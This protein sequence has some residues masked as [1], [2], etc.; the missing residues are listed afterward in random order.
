MPPR[1]PF[2]KKLPPLRLKN[3]LA[4]LF[5]LFGILPLLFANLVA[6]NS[7]RQSILDAHKAEMQERSGILATKLTRTGYLRSRDKKDSNLNTEIEA[8]AQ[9][10]RGRVIVVD[11][12]YRIIADSFHL[13]E[14]RYHVAPEVVRG[15][16][17]ENG[18]SYNA[19]KYYMIQ[20]TPIYNNLDAKADDRQVEGVLLFM[21]STEPQ[22]SELQSAKETLRIF[23]VVVAVLLALL[24]ALLTSMIMRPFAELRTALRKVS[25]GDLNQTVEQHSYLVTSQIS[26]DVNTTLRKLRTLNESREEFVS[27]VSHELKTPITS[28]RVLADSLIGMGDAP[29]ELYKEFM[30]D[31]SKEIDR[32]AKIIDDLLSLVRMDRAATVLSRKETN[33]HEML[34][35]I[36]KRLRPL[37]KVNQ[38]ELT[39]HTVREVSADVDEVKFSL[40]IMN[41]VENGIKYNGKQKDGYVQVSLDADH[42]F[43]YIRVEDNGIGIPEDQQEL[44][45]ERFHRVDKARSRETGGTGLGLAI[46]KEIILL[47]QGM[48]RLSSEEGKGTTFQVRIPLKYIES[49]TPAQAASQKEK[50][51]KEEN[52]K[53]EKNRKEKKGGE[54][55]AK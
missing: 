52:R 47:H 29:L 30:S 54:K 8:I 2:M 49:S 21:S 19:D 45:F 23:M 25:A 44:V 15:F 7:F 22:R 5:L 13:T 43:C 48:I 37:A 10:L 36:L 31:I 26:E 34:E 4:V 50:N 33:M 35:Q 32:E 3:M 9:N 12:N 42:Q 16:R 39:L 20:T 27:N 1:P 55:R 28:M 46:T 14:G 40:A 38:I 41:L 53:E 18:T 6:T 24:S 11:Q 51:R 17:G